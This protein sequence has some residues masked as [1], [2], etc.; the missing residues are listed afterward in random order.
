MLWKRLHNIDDAVHMVWHELEA[1]QLDLRVK[2]RELPPCS[3]DRKTKLGG[4][5]PW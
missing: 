5:N 2:L 3:F 1:K 4:R